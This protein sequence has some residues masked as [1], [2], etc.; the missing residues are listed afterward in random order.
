MKNARHILT[1]ILAVIGSQRT[2][3]KADDFC[4]WV[5]VQVMSGLIEALPQDKQ[6]QVID[7]FVTL[8]DQKKE[9]VF[10]PY[11]TLEQIRQTLTQ[12]TKKAI[13]QQIVEPRSHQLSP[14]QR[15]SILTL[16]EQLTC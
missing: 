7:Q 8:P 13:A 4:T 12:A 9:S 11:Y 1:Q 5:E 14:S 2:E 16:L 15:E 6:K 3:R 10:Y